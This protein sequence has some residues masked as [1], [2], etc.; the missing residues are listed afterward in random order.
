MDEELR[1]LLVSVQRVGVRRTVQGA[2]R[3]G[4]TAGAVRAALVLRRAV[5]DPE[6]CRAF[7]VG[8]RLVRETMGRV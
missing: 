1:G 5:K 6:A 4:G 2:E 3:E 8:V 7:P